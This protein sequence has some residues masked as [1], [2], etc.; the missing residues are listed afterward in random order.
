MKEVVTEPEPPRNSVYQKSDVIKQLTEKIEKMEE[1]QCFKFEHNILFPI[2]LGINSE[3]PER[4]YFISEDK[5][6]LRELN[7]FLGLFELTI[8]IRSYSQVSRHLY[9]LTLKIQHYKY[10]L[11]E[12]NKYLEAPWVQSNPCIF[13]FYRYIEWKKEQ[14]ANVKDPIDQTYLNDLIHKKIIFLIGELLFNPDDSFNTDAQLTECV[15]QLT[16]FCLDSLEDTFDERRKKLYYTLVGFQI[17]EEWYVRM[18]GDYLSFLIDN[19]NY[20]CV[21]QIFAQTGK[22]S[23]T[24]ATRLEQSATSTENTK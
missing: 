15:N 16:Q 17:K 7:T 19:H 9:L 2:L 10:S 11:L 23:S 4:D 1:M 3:T 18:L 14:Q 24:S 12:I 22:G 21:A 6:F 20:E 5:E 13:S 8:P